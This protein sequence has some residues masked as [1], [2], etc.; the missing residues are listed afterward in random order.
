MKLLVCALA[1]VSFV[2]GQSAQDAGAKASAALQG[3]WQLVSFNGQEVPS[4]A[5]AYLVF[6]GDKYEQWTGNNVDERGSIRLDAS[7]TPMAIDLVIV[8]GN[9][10]GKTQLGVFEIKG[11]TMW[12]TLALPGEGTRPAGLGSGELQVVLRK[13][14]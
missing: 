4:E 2:G 8:E 1:M 6:K 5:E 14:K 11:E 13:S 10:G 12:L 3:N 9:D 7:K